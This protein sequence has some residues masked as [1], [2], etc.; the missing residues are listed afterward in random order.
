MKAGILQCLVIADLPAAWSETKKQIK[1]LQLEREAGVN[2]RSREAKIHQA[3]WQHSAGHTNTPTLM[4]AFMDPIT[5]C[6]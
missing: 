5:L 6:E 3:N 2:G 1:A 4:F